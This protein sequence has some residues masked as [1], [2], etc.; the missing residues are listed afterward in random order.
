MVPEITPWVNRERLPSV[1]VNRDET[2]RGA[3][4][5]YAPDYRALG[6][7]GAVLVRKILKGAWP[8]DL[9]IEVP[10]KLKLTLNLNTAKAIGLN[11]PRE[12]LVRA[13]ELAE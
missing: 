11:I 4:A 13:D 10:R 5:S 1:A 8:G 2:L 6:E 12:L 7:Q 9:P 3:L